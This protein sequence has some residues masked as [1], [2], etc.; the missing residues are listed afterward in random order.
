M[1]SY[2]QF[3]L[4]TVET[5]E[6]KNTIAHCDEAV[7]SKLLHI[8]LSKV[9]TKS[10]TQLL[11]GFHELMTGQKILYV[12]HGCVGFDKWFSSSGILNSELAA[13]KA[14]S[15]RLYKSGNRVLKESF[16]AI[17]QMRTEGLTNN[18][19]NVEPKLLQSL[20]SIIKEPTV[21]NVECVLAMPAFSHLLQE[22]VCTSD[23][24]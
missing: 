19:K 3:L 14:F 4:Q 18:Y 12:K 6:L 10:I 13:E 21:D 9:D 22:I 1:H 11:G 17:V 5:L 16:D 15:G 7:Y 8:I 20:L 2:R 24:I 23:T